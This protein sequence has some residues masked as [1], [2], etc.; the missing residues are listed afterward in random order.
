MS[1]ATPIER[2]GEHVDKWLN[3]PRQMWLLGAGISKD[4]GIPLMYPLTSRVAALLASKGEELG[5]ADTSASL[6]IYNSIVKDLAKDS[7]VE[8]ALSQIGD[9]ISL[10]QRKNVRKVKL[11]TLEATDEELRLTHHHVQLAIRYTVENGYKAAE[12]GAKEEIGSEIK[13]IVTRDHHDRFVRSLFT[14]RRAGLEQNPAVRFFTTNYDLLLEDALAHAQVPVVDGFSSGGT[15]FWDPKNNDYRLEQAARFAQHTAL[16]CKLHGSIDWA[17][18]EDDG[19]MRLR[20]MAISRLDG[21]VQRLLIYPQATKYQ[22]TQRDPFASLFTEFRRALNVSTPSVLCICGYSFG[23]E[24]I[25]EEIERAMRQASNTLTVLAF[26][27][28]RKDV[29]GTLDDN[30]GLPA[31]MAGWLKRK[32]EWS[33]RIIVAGRHGFYRGC[34]ENQLPDAVTKEVPWWTFGGLIDFLQRGPEAIT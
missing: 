34:L 2:A 10:A 1:G 33:K 26:C 23:D 11:G 22:V 31:T 16:V 30:Q 14:I 27:Y 5:S 24:H 18:G 32:T 28:Q 7:H 13:P 6:K 19:V 17:C 8:H 29:D 15:A 3:V 20:S 4:A 21:I 9:L 12:G 25:N